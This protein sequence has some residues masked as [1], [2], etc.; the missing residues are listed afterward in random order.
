MQINTRVSSVTV[1][2]KS[3]SIV[4]QGDKLRCETNAHAEMRLCLSVAIPISVSVSVSVSL[5]ISVSVSISLPI[6]VS[7]AEVQPWW[8]QGI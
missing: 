2:F 7:I 8:I 1:T 4:K 6:S 5:P 3:Y